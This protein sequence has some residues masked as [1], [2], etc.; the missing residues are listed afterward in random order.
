ME[1][2]RFARTDDGV[3]LGFQVFGQ[4]PALVWMPSLSNILAQWRI[5]AVRAAYLGLSKHLTVVL[6]DGRGTGSSDR[7]VDLDDLGVDAHL[8]DLRAVLDH[9]GLQRATLLGYYHSV[10]TAIAFAAREPERVERLVLFGGAPRMREAMLPAQTQALLSLVEQDWGLFADAAAT[11]WLGWDAAPSGRF[12]AEAFRTATSAPVAKAWFEAAR[13]IDVT[14]ELARVRA[15]ALV[16]HRQ[17]AEQIPVEVARR[18]AAALPD[19]RL[20]ELPGSTPTL[21]MENP[22]A[23]LKLVTDFVTHGRVNRPSTAPTTL[24]PRETDVLRLLAAGDSNTEI[25]RQLGIAVHTVERHLAN[26]YRK[27]GARG[28]TDAV[29]Y[30]LRMTEFRHPG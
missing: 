13:E 22:A 30:A 8:R 4:G 24:T 6:Y 26:L 3:T 2:L 14:A 29:A 9:A 1:D 12:T 15:P 27:I 25:A 16:L 21:F 10:A 20:V 19:A 18:M 17:S 5:P 23:D 7:R 28:R 11:A